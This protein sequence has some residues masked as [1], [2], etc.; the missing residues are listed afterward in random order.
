VRGPCLYPA[1]I[2]GSRRPAGAG[3]LLVE[4]SERRDGVFGLGPRLGIVRDGR[5]A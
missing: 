5:R 1:A 3:S 2:V 4:S